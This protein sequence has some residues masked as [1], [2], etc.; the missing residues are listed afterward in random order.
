VSAGFRLLRDG[1]GDG[2]WNMAVDALL[3]ERAIRGASTLRLYTWRGAWLSLGHAQRLARP[4]RD[5]CRDAGV[6]VVRRIT[7]GRAVLHGADLTY[8]LA[9]PAAALPA[10]L[11]ASYALVTDVLLAALRSLG[12]AAVRSGTAGPA[13]RR[14]FDCFADPAPEEI[15][16]AGRKL[17]GSAQRRAR[18]AL[19]QHGS[20]RL[21]ADPARMRA[22]ALGAADPATSLAEL[23][24]EGEVA[25][26][27]E[28][29][30][31]AFEAALGPLMKAALGPA[32]R[33]R[34]RRLVTGEPP[35]APV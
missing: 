22:A 4:R 8:A 29:C 30:I 32:E 12:I 15:C 17:C 10:G 21:H 18:G 19:L 25:A 33:D 31:A 16:A 7:G 26:V 6:G 34:A 14:G 35:V 13:Q 11:E 3:L 5:A 28:A 23:G 2:P 20:L 9:A 1:A 27:E 24:F